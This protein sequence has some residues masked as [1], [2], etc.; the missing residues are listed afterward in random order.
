MAKRDQ[1]ATAEKALRELIAA[2]S[3]VEY[4]VALTTAAKAEILVRRARSQSRSLS[5]SFASADE[6]TEEC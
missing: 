3:D 4:G 1:A 6:T 2:K 5:R